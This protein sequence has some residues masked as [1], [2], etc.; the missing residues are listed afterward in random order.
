MPD[1]GRHLGVLRDGRHDV[2]DGFVG[3]VVRVKDP[4]GIIHGRYTHVE[5][6]QIAVV[7]AG[8]AVPAG[9]HDPNQAVCRVFQQITDNSTG[10]AVHH[11]RPNH[12]SP[13]ALTGRLKDQL[14]VIRTPGDKGNRV[15]RRVLVGL[16][17]LSKHPRSGRVHERRGKSGRRPSRSGGDERIDRLTINLLFSRRTV[18]AMLCTEMVEPVV[19]EGLST[20]VDDPALDRMLLVL[21]EDRRVRRLLVLE[22]HVEDRVQALAAC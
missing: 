13:D 7:N 18:L 9:A 8:P 10:S 15:D 12:D 21:L 20:F 3:L 17:R 19:N 6:G 11:S 4:G 22:R 14:L 16:V 5:V 2:V 1:I